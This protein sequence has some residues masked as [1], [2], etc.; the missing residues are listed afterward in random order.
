MSEEEKEERK[1]VEPEEPYKLMR[2]L[3]RPGRKEAKK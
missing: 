1:Q 3:L 2:K